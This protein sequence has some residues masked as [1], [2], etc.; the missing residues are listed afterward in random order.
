MAGGRF[1]D[2]VWKP[3][4]V[5]YEVCLVGQPM[6]SR[7]GSRNG[8]TADLLLRIWVDTSLDLARGCNG[9]RRPSNEPHTRVGGI[10]LLSNSRSN[11]SAQ[12]REHR[13][14]RSSGEYKCKCQFDH[15]PLL[16]FECPYPLLC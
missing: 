11:A 1:T 5:G 15:I 3:A 12:T 13:H 16:F 14:S 4:L 8:G 6:T 2:R 10:L 9:R 7:G